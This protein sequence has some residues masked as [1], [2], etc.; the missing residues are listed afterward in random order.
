MKL[1]GKAEGGREGGGISQKPIEVNIGH[2]VLGLFLL[3]QPLL[4]VIIIC[5]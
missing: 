2:G 4:H 1:G 5:C 3:H